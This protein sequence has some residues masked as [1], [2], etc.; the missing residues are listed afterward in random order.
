MFGSGITQAMEQPLTGL[1]DFKEQMK[2]ASQGDVECQHMVA[3]KYFHGIDVPVNQLEAIQW[4]RKAA[5]HGHAKAQYNLGRVLY[6]GDGVAQDKSEALRWICK[7]AEQGFPPAQFQLAYH[8]L[9]EKDE[10]HS[11]EKIITLFRKAAEAGHAEAC[12][13]LGRC[14]EAGAGVAQDS[15]EAKRWLSLAEANGCQNAVHTATAE[16]VDRWKKEADVGDVVSMGKMGRCYLH[17]IHVE[18]DVAKAL[19]LHLKAARYG[20]KDAMF[21]LSMIYSMGLGVD[22]NESEAQ[23]WLDLSYE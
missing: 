8:Y 15:M 19:E 3:Y 9:C 13:W 4:W 5:E 16:C 11:S 20:N 21:W 6:L 23:K 22:A 2:L 10:P 7:A 12:H 17:G 14:Y 1:I 18:K